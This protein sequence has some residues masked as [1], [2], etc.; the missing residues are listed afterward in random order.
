MEVPNHIF[1]SF[2]LPY[3][4]D[5][6]RVALSRVSSSVPCLV[7]RKFIEESPPALL[8]IMVDDDVRSLLARGMYK[9]RIYIACMYTLWSG[10][11]SCIDMIPD[12]E[13]LVNFWNDACPKDKYEDLFV[14]FNVACCLGHIDALVCVCR[15]VAWEKFFSVQ[16]SWMP[17]IQRSSAITS[18]CRNGHARVVE[19]LVTN[20]N[21]EYL[22][23]SDE[24]LMY[25]DEKT[26]VATTKVMAAQLIGAS[27]SRSTDNDATIT[28]FKRLCL[29]GHLPSVVWLCD[30]YSITRE[31]LTCS[32]I[33]DL[34]SLL[35]DICSRDYVH[36]CKWVMSYFD[37]MPSGVNYVARHRVFNPTCVE[38][39]ELL[40]TFVGSDLK[41]A[42]VLELFCIMC[43]R[44]KLRAAKW[45]WHSYPSSV[46][47]IFPCEETLED[48]HI[49]VGAC[50]TRHLHVV[51]WLYTTFRDQITRDMTQCP[52]IINAQMLMTKSSR[53]GHV[54]Q[55]LEKE[56]IFF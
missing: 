2:V 19:W 27:S 25:T 12:E 44:G 15:G 9:D 14:A 30:T 5:L 47:L 54:R 40:A 18:A 24:Y 16:V 36:V 8:R 56:C 10:R 46:N 13:E 11:T 29:N 41:E 38:A 3:L 35:V 33:V 6:N 28:L 22:N 53:H 21:R 48:L 7:D 45:L 37:W 55:Y 34:D 39:L 49:F 26:N 20:I 1:Q 23:V 4:D 42:C 50:S 52:D 51:R 32:C 43:M 17:Y 31:V